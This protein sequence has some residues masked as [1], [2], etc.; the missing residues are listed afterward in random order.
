MK[1]SKEAQASVLPPGKRQ[2]QLVQ[3]QDVETPEE[4]E[5]RIGQ[6]ALDRHCYLV[7][8]Y[9]ITQHDYNALLASQGGVCGI[10]GSDDPSKGR[11][12]NKFFCVDHDHITGRVRGLL[13]VPCNTGLGRLGDNVASLERAIA[14]LRA[15][16]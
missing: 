9:G 10:C 6:E 7:R 13:C 1:Y 16:V 11:A 8:K 4:I 15:T 3:L 14:Y 5:N 2:T 12:G